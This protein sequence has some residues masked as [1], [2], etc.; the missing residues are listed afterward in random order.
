MAK[1][2]VSV[3]R[4]NGSYAGGADVL[5]KGCKEGGGWVE[6]RTG[7]RRTGCGSVC[8]CRS[9]YLVFALSLCIALG[10]MS[11]P[12]RMPRKTVPPSFVCTETA[13]INTAGTVIIW[14]TIK[15]SCM[16]PR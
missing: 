14:A 15:S 3:E 10:A 13:Q 4:H 6:G 2:P 16:S 5:V 12:V 1:T 11:D 9:V 7:G 8:G